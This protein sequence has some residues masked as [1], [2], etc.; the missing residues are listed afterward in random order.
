M[1]ET[2]GQMVHTVM[3]GNGGFHFE[4][5]ELRDVPVGDIGGLFL[6]STLHEH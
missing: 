6:L 2:L 4:P 3:V 1:R 5:A